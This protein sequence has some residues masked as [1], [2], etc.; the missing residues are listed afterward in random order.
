MKANEDLAGGATLAKTSNY[1]VVAA[2]RNTTILVDATSGNIT[3]TLLPAATATD[4]FRV[5][6]K[7]IDATA[8][9]VTIDGN[10]SETIDGSLTQ[11]L[12]LQYDFLPL[13]TNASNWFKENPLGI[14]KASAAEMEAETANKYPDASLVKYSPGVAKATGL[15][16]A[17]G[18]SVAGFAY[19][20]GCTSVA[21]N[22][23][24]VYTITLDTAMSSANYV[25]IGNGYRTAGSGDVI[26]F[27]RNR[28]TTT[29]QLYATTTS[30]NPTDAEISFSVFGDL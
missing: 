23:T 15:F 24:G 22:S 6:V 26:V 1:T 20:Y 27:T 14:T 29:F 18:G 9:T 30:S 11:V 7:K 16:D 4:G 10:A 21:R 3:I 5:A 12:A 2:D 28:T 8:N 25:V 19:E 13:V 17:N